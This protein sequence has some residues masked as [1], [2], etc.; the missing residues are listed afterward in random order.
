MYITCQ[1]VGLYRE[2]GNNKAR[3][4]ET[5]KDNIEYCYGC[6]R[7][8]ETKYSLR[9]WAT[10]KKGTSREEL[11]KEVEIPEIIEGVTTHI[12]FLNT[13]YAYNHSMDT[14]YC[15]EIIQKI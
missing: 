6:D 12:R 1:L 8:Y 7:E 13:T 4:E 3:W 5:H 9:I 11:L 15:C 2:K 14:I 10:N